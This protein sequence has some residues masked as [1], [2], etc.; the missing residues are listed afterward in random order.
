MTGEKQLNVICNVL[1][2]LAL[3]VGSICAVWA[4]VAQGIPLWGIGLVIAGVL[5]A[6]SWLFSTISLEFKRRG[7]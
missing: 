7:W 3:V 1:F 5:L 6:W 2:V 4:A